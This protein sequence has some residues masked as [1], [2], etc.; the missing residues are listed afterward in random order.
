MT[1]ILKM[2]EQMS[3]VRLQLCAPTWQFGVASADAWTD[4]SS[5]GLCSCCLLLVT[6]S[7]LSSEKKQNKDIMES[8]ACNPAAWSRL[9]TSAPQWKT[10]SPLSEPFDTSVPENG[11]GHLRI[12]PVQRLSLICCQRAAASEERGDSTA[13]TGRVLQAAARI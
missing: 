4:I 8:K 2:N 11:L 1:A 5:E 10:T 3:D 9:V 12:F 7:W 6:G 13:S